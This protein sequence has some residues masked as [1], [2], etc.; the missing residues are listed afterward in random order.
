MLLAPFHFCRLGMND[1]VFFALCHL[2]LDSNPHCLQCFCSGRQIIIYTAR[3]F[4][5][6]TVIIRGKHMNQNCSGL[7]ALVV[8]L[9]AA[10]AV[11]ANVVTDWD[12]IAV[13]TI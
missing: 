11:S 4:A 7:I 13:K 1:H 5:P 6:C 12:E 3:L 2:G 8:M 10:P 9:T